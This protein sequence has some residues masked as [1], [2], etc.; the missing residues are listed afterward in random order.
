M[1]AQGQG[2]AVPAG[3]HARDLRRG[4]VLLI[5]L[6]ALV[7]GCTA[8]LPREARWEHTCF[9]P[10]NEMVF[11]VAGG[12]V[13]NCGYANPERSAPAA[14]VRR[15][16]ASGEPFRA[17]YGANGVDSG[18]CVAAVRKADGSLWSVSIPYD[19]SFPKDDE[20]FG[21]KLLVQRCD[22]LALARNGSGYEIPFAFRNC[23]IDK[24]AVDRLNQQLSAA[25]TAAG[26][27][28]LD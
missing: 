4:G 14:C 8:A 19:F 10:L 5:V 13:T 27:K 3:G 25:R 6:A 26:E 22:A 9:G 12:E 23:H 1:S 28:S 11:A 24:A 7:G 2:R 17:A 15:S 18:L 16:L 20:R 21:P